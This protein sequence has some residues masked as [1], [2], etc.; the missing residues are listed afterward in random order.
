ME[1]I[2][3]KTQVA[4]IRS[5]EKGFIAIHLINLGA[6]LGIWEALY[7]EKDGLTISDLAA[8]LNL[9]EPY[10]KIWCQTAYHYQILDADKQGRFKLQPFLDEVLGDKTH[11]RNYLAN[12]AMDVKIIGTF[13]IAIELFRTGRYAETYN[14][15]EFSE[16]AYG[17]T[18]NIYLAFLYLILPKA[19]HLKQKLEQ[20]IRFL[21]IGCGNG[22]FII[23]LAQVFRNSTFVGV[24]PDIH[25]VKSARSTI[26]Q[27]GLGNRVTVEHT[28]GESMSY[29]DE[30]DMASMVLTLHEIRP[31]VRE[32]VVKKA[33]QALKKN[34]RLLVLDFPYPNKL[35][36]F[37]N[38]IFDFA[39]IDQAFE[40]FG[41]FFHLENEQQNEII[42]N[43]GFTNIQRMSIGKMFDFI[44]A[45][46]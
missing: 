22:N 12:I 6:E 40:C 16:T 24:T 28:G 15:P 20:G 11:F 32:E 1:E 9:H 23:Q 33:Y 21:D 5:F 18:K 27:L 30:F 34:G 37:R 46:K 19:E 14:S 4:K 38:P 44:T 10:L 3:A 13:P 8:R 25:G 41:G 2:S 26:S 45:I 17:P 36:D 29:K 43:A 35:E 31:A 39:I 7:K 42:V